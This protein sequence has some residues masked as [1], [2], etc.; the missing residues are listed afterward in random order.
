MSD[1]RRGLPLLS[2]PPPTPPS[3][4]SQLDGCRKCGKEFNLIF[5]RSRK[6]NHC[7]YLYCHSCSD[8]QAL[9]P[10]TGSETGYDVLP[11][12][13][14][15]IDYLTITAAG[16]GYLKSLP[17]G[18]LKTYANAYRIGISHAVEKDDVI[19]AILS[20]RG[21]N[22][23]LPAENE[24][25]FR[26]HSVP[27]ADQRPGLRN[28]FR[29]SPSDQPGTSPPPPPPP[30][31]N[32][33]PPFAR[34]DLAPDPPLFQHQQGSPQAHHYSHFGPPPTP[35]SINSF[36]RP[37]VYPQS[38]T[39]P[40]YQPPPRPHSEWSQYPGQQ[41]SGT[42]DHYH[43]Y[44]VPNHPPPPP[45]PQA[46]RP[47]PTHQPPSAPPVPPPRPQPT[48]QPTSRPPPAAPPSLNELLNIPSEDVKKLSISALKSV[49][50]TN[51]VNAGQVL[52]KEELVK[53]VLTLVEDERRDRE[54]QRQA[55]EL[56]EMER[57]Q[58]EQERREEVERE[59]RERRNREQEQQRAAEEAGNQSSGDQASGEAAE[60]NA[61]PGVDNNEP[62]TNTNAKPSTPQSPPKPI[63]QERG[64]LC[65]ICQDEEANIAI[66]DCGHM[67]MCRGCSDLIMNS[68]RECP[69]CRT[70]IVT[71]ARLLRIFKA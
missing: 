3:N 39:R 50:F 68:S 23:C 5:A 59:Q 54:R 13:G 10:R 42:Y 36:A 24:N 20:K 48:S 46:S 31:Q 38:Q 41:H 26:R 53:K 1:A 66:V 4:A 43:N 44:H 25:Y 62:R 45:P 8:Y 28:M 12:C 65:V 6:C 11:V 49:L 27:I 16:K 29:S 69:L 17:L 63:V 30:P 67:V 60:P 64:G 33:P 55:E 56:E 47:S 7:G 51:H 35:P 15:C 57:L 71:E 34:P 61:R 21:P 58:R 2:G 40:Q 70:R 9:M 32:R 18:K 19:E 22:G 52:E 14:H 37:H